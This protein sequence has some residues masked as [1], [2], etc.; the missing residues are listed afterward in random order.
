[1]NREFSVYLTSSVLYKRVY[2]LETKCAKLFF[3]STEPNTLSA[4]ENYGIL[5]NNEQ[6]AKS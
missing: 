5:C 2:H 1:M 6:Y 4:I 3:P